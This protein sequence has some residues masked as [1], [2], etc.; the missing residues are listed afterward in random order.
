VFGVSVCCVLSVCVVCLGFESDCVYM[1]GVCECG[2]CV[3][4]MCVVCLCFVFSVMLVCGV[5]V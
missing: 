2:F 4:G 1:C 5:H 3:T